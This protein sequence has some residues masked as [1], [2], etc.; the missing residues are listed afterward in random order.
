VDEGEARQVSN[1]WWRLCPS[2]LVQYNNVLLSVRVK[3]SCY[4]SN[5]VKF[6]II[7]GRLLPALSSALG[8]P[9]IP[10]LA[11]PLDSAGGRWSTNSPETSTS[12][13]PLDSQINA[14]GAVGGLHACVRFGCSMKVEKHCSNCEWWWVIRQC[15]MAGWITTCCGLIVSC[16]SEVLHHW[17][18]Q[19]IHRVPKTTGTPSSYW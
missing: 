8:S 18:I 2:C 7:I 12:P 9:Q 6:C 4:V 11:L 17:C 10:T 3:W 14:R 1:R 16:W 19:Y 5:M 15:D 13:T